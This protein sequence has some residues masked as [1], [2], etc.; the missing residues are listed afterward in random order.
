MKGSTGN[1][2]YCQI[3][4]QSRRKK[5]GLTTNNT[6]CGGPAAVEGRKHGCRGLRTHVLKD[7][8]G[9]GEKGVAER[10]PYKP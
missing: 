9:K 8:G 4:L 2:V 10:T 3:T 1:Q 5:G 6:T 7:R